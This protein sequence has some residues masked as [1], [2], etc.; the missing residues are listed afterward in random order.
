[1]FLSARL[2]RSPKL[3]LSSA[4]H[5]LVNGARDDDATGRRFCFQAGSYVHS[6]TVEVIAIHDQVAEI[7]ADTEHDS[8]VFG[9]ILVGVGHGLLKFDG[10]AKSTH[11]TR[12]FNQR[13]I[14]GEFDQSATV[15]R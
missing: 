5:R 3:A 13:T 6:V 4:R 1:M 9:L 8:G 15:T 2:P 7:H 12:E 14:A 10:G 11:C